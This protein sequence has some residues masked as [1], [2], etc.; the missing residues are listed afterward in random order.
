MTRRPYSAGAVKLS[1]WFPEFRKTVQLLAD[2]NTREEIRRLS[3]E[4]NLYGT[5]TKRRADQL[6]RTVLTRAE[7]LDS[8]FYPVFLAGDLTTQKLF[9]LAAI[10]ATDTLFFDFMYEVF[11]EKQRTGC[12]LLEPRDLRVFFRDKQMQDDRAARW[13]E[14]TC[15][16]L[17]AS[18]RT[19]LSEAGLIDRA[20]GARN[21]LSPLVSPALR[22][23]LETH[24]MRP[25]LKSW[26][27]EG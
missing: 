20:A 12:R 5:R 6:C 19:Y 18:Y 27:G 25:I 2:G 8:S 1:F 26:T 16:R 13:T 3:I 7:A 17:S 24:D 23:W 4:E 11:R 14:E 9:A 21:I 22:G 10:M 15:Q